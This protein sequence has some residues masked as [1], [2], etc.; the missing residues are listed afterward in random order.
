[1]KIIAPILTDT[2]LKEGN[3]DTNVS[4]FKQSVDFCSNNGLTTL[5]HLGDIFDS[6]KAQP[7]VVLSTFQSILDYCKVKGVNLVA[8]PGNHEK[9]DYKSVDSFLDPFRH[10][11]SFTLIDTY[12][13]TLLTDE[14]TIHFIPFFKDEQ[15]NEVL[16]TTDGFINN[17]TKNILFTHIGITGAKM[18]NGSEVEGIAPIDFKYFDK[19][20]IGH[21]HDKQIFGKF[22][23]VG[24]SIQ[25]NYGETPDKGLTLLYSDLSFQTLELEFP[26]FLKLEVDINKLTPNDIQEIC[27]EKLISNDNLRVILVGSEDKIK[28]FNKQIFLEKGVS[29]QVKIDD[30]VKSE[31]DDRVEPFT[32][33]SILE[34]YEAYCKKNDIVDQQRG[35][36][37]LKKVLK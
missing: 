24:S 26:K 30:V 31:I 19:V 7:L 1:M 13:S 22:N 11:P 15:Y 33:T 3:L 8:I 6:R 12:F 2:H 35:L 4:I 21:Y 25:H 23:Y 18:N 29:V 37:Y 14:V 16:R 28:S 36:N 32:S 20:F 17:A 5:Y 27:N 9:T 10:H 34:Q